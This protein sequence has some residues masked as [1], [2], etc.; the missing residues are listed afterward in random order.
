MAQRQQT[1]SL[2]MCTVQIFG[3]NSNK[4]KSDSGGNQEETEFR[5][6]LLSISASCL[7]SKNEKIRIYKTIIL[8]VTLYGYETLCLT[9]REDNRLRVFENGVLRRIFGL[10]RVEVTKGWRKLHNGELHI[11]CSWPSIIRMIE[12]REMRWS[13]HMAQM[14]E[15]RNGYRILVGKL[16]GKRPPGRQRCR[17]L[18]NIK[19]DLGEIDCGSMGWVSLD[20][21]QWRAFVN[22][23]V[24]LW[25]P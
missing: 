25:I 22:V 15:K 1:G 23:T 5:Y 13:G 14:G 3:N 7:L 20:R 9:L 21:D 16:E 18:D 24:N 8:P 10:R 19:I 11:L 12:S 2:K 4:S 6:C 17:W